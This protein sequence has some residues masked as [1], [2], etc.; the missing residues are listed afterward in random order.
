MSVGLKGMAAAG[1]GLAW[2]PESLVNTELADG[3]LVRAAD[4]EWNIEVEI[5]LYRSRENR[6]PIVGL[7]WSMLDKP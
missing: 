4:P 1:F 2:I 5:R 3:R 6:R 7:V